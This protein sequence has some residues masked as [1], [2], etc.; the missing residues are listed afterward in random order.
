MKRFEVGDSVRIDI[1]DQS[2]PD[3]NQ[4]HDRSGEIVKVIED[5]AGWHT[6]DERDSY[7]F[8][9]E[10]KNGEREHFRWRD[11]RPDS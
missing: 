9:V 8:G 1:P 11:L 4:Y 2:D 10:F 6:G 7:L 5:D 3:F